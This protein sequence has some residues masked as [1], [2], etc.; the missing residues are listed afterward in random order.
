MYVNKRKFGITYIINIKQIKYR[1]ALSRLKRPEN[2]YNDVVY[3]Q[4]YN[5]AAING[6]I[7]CSIFFME[8]ILPK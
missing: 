4:V 1:N 6:A 7:F 8:Y 5:G 3:I 2:V